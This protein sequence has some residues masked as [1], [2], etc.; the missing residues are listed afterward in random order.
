MNNKLLL[1][2]VSYNV[3]KFDKEGNANGAETFNIAEDE[4]YEDMLVRVRGYFRVPD[5]TAVIKTKNAEH[6]GIRNSYTLIVD[7]LRERSM[8]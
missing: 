5:K 3:R 8:K 2:I 4:T 6:K 1:P 7:G